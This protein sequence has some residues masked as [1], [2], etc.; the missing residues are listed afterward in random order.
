MKKS[1]LDGN[2]KPTKNINIVPKEMEEVYFYWTK[3]SID[4]MVW[5]GMV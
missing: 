1:F 5:Y 3:F 4:G 2:L